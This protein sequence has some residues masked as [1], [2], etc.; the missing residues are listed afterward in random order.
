MPEG[1][2]ERAVEALAKS[3]DGAE[4]SGMM[5]GVMA[6]GQIGSHDR[7]HVL[8]HGAPEVGRVTDQIW[9]QNAALIAAQS[10]P[11]RWRRSAHNHRATPTAHRRASRGVNDP[12]RSGAGPPSAQDAGVVHTTAC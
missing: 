1:R 9:L 4:H 7:P 3:I 12:I 5:K 10:P 2:A 8:G 6:V 11:T